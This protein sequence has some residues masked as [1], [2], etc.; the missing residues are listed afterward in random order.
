[1]GRALLSFASRD[2]VSS[3]T[4]LDAPRRRT[5]LRLCWS[6][7]LLFSLQL[8][9]F[10]SV[11]AQRPVPFRGTLLDRFFTDR[12]LAGATIEI[13]GTGQ[14]TV[15]DSLGRFAFS[16][17]EPGP[18]T[19]LL[20]HPAFAAVGITMPARDVRV[21][22]SSGRVTVIAAE[23]SALL[24][25]RCG[26]PIAAGTTAVVGLLRDAASGAPISGGTVRAEWTELRFGIGRGAGRSEVARQQA[27][28]S[29]A[30]GLYVLCAVP[31]DVILTVTATAAERSSGPVPVDPRDVRVVGQS[32]AL[33]A[34]ADVRAVLAGRLVDTANAPVPGG[35]VALLGDSARARAG[36]DGRFALTLPRP[37]TWMLEARGIGFV[38]MQRL[39]QARPG[40]SE[41]GD[42]RLEITPRQLE[43]LQVIADVTGFE[44]RRRGKIGQFITAEDIARMRP[45][46]TEDAIRYATGALF[47]NGFARPQM[48]FL[49]GGRCQ[50]AVFIDGRPIA[51]GTVEQASEFN[52]SAT[53]LA[54]LPR[55]ASSGDVGYELPLDVDPEQ[56]RGIEI[57]DRSQVIPPSIL[58]QL[59]I[60]PP[61]FEQLQ[62]SGCAVLIWTWRNTRGLQRTAAR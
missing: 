51:R 37:G 56:V 62:G 52:T 23:R 38:P 44:R 39:L 5:G 3:S 15:T 35:L 12:P 16:E 6:A 21:D 34:G 18:H 54:A 29:D 7:A 1:M 57:Y 22:A 24:A 13:E 31:D 48:V 4:P 25:K 14:R 11:A 40:R 36:D 50:P 20:G 43:E 45:E 58:S 55:P 19:L 32:L 59:F 41:L 8:G 28:V 27:T 46:R 33:G 47:P 30:D 42:L 10:A 60:A 49:K 26:G 61:D 17:V 9:L 53:G 2:A